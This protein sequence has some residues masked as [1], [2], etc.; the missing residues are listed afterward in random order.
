MF[1]DNFRRLFPRNRK[2]GVEMMVRLKQA[3]GE[4]TYKREDSFD[5]ICG[6]FNTTKVKDV[7]S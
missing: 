3:G 1:F 2:A 5:L 6:S 7:S 4:Q